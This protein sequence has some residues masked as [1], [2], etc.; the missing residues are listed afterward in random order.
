MKRISLILIVVFLISAC[1]M[2][3]VGQATPTVFVDFPTAAPQASPTEGIEPTLAPLPTDTVEPSPTIELA[4]ATLPAPTDTP[5]PEG[6]AWRIPAMPGTEFVANEKKS[7]PE[8]DTIM[9]DQARN[10]AVS[11]PYFWDIYAIAA[12]TRYKTV[13]DYFVSVITQTGYALSLDVQGADEIYLMS[14]IKK[15]TKSKI[16][17]QFNGSTAKRKSA[18]ILILYTNP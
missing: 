7:D 17:V 3:P 9:S 2:L 6:E 12:G 14:F 8:F 4:S 11:P 13:K 16:Y 15:Q 1:S 18:A 5:T 10:L